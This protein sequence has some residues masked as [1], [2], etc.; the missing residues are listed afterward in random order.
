MASAGSRLD[1]FLLWSFSGIGSHGS[2][3]PVDASQS[4][5]ANQVKTEAVQSNGPAHPVAEAPPPVPETNANGCSQP[6]P[7]SPEQNGSLEPEAAPAKRCRLEAE[8]LGQSEQEAS[9][10]QEN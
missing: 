3:P 10:T 6:G 8:P 2:N 1:L 7:P 9:R 4:Q 5:P